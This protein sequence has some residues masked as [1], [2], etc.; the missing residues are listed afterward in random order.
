MI[1]N[2]YL[3]IGGSM[4]LWLDDFF[5]GFSFPLS[6][7][8]FALMFALMRD[9]QN[10][11]IHLL[12]EASFWIV[13]LGVI[14]FFVFIILNILAAEIVMA[15]ILLADVLLIFY[16]FKRDSQD[17]E[18]SQFLTS[19]LTF[20]T[21]TGVTGIL[22]LLWHLLPNGKA[23]EQNLLLQIHAYLSLYGW[24]LSGLTIIV[25][26]DEF[27]LRLHDTELILLH[28]LTIALLAP[29]GSLYPTFALV[30]LP[31][32]VLLLTFIFFVRG[33]THIA[34]RRQDFSPISIP[35]WQRAK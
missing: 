11:V 10:G 14:V 8:T 23:E 34:A 3:H 2:E 21:F 1:N 12:Q 5:L 26:Y 20:L 27:P 25:R 31:A 33:Q 7:I 30:A 35:F 18:Q 29:L 24:N 17:L 32:F 19:G 6:L 4:D 28:W 9:P 22:L 13:T 15:T 16:L